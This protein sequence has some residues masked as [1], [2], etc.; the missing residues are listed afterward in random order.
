M[1]ESIQFLKTLEDELAAAGS[2]LALRRRKRSRRLRALAL[3]TVVVAATGF[4]VSQIIG[5]GELVK[6]AAEDPAVT[7]TVTTPAVDSTDSVDSSDSTNS[8]DSPAPVEG[9]PV[10]DR[11]DPAWIPLGPLESRGQTIEVWTGTELIVYGGNTGDE[12]PLLRTG[13][14]Y[15]PVAKSWR[16]IADAPA[17]T[18]SLTGVWTGS[19]LLVSSGTNT[20]FYDPAV[21]SWSQVEAG[22]G[23][24]QIVYL[25]AAYVMNDSG[26]FRFD[27]NQW[28]PLPQP[29]GSIQTKRDQFTSQLLVH[30]DQITV[31]SLTEEYCQGRRLARFD[32][33]SWLELPPVELVSV[34]G[35]FADCSWANQVGVAGGRLIAWE[36]RNF[37]TVALDEQR[38]EWVEIDTIPVSSTEG[39]TGGVTIGN[40]LLVPQSPA[41]VLDGDSLTWHAA[42]LPGPGFD[43]YMVW[44]GDRVLMWGSPCCYGTGGRLTAHDA[45]QWEPT[46]PQEPGSWTV[47]QIRD[48]QAR[49]GATYAIGDEWLFVWGGFPDRSPERPTSSLT[50]NIDTGEASITPFSPPLE[51]RRHAT[52]VWTGTE[53]IVFGGADDEQAYTNGGRISPVE[54]KWSAI[55]KSPFGP[56]TT[57]A[58]AWVADRMFVWMPEPGSPV[59]RRGP[60]Q[61]ASYSP[62]SDTWELLEAPPVSVVG[63]ELVDQGD[64][65]LLVGGPPMRDIGTVAPFPPV[66]IAAY[67]LATGSWDFEREIEEN[68]ESVRTID[69]DGALHIIDDSGF[70]TPLDSERPTIAAPTTGCWYDIATA[71]SSGVTYLKACGGV[72]IYADGRFDPILA[73]GDPASTGNTYGSGFVAVPDGRLVVFGPGRANH[74][75][76]FIG[77]YERK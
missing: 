33:S 29:P 66:Q 12:T 26:I 51:P 75:G 38:G 64:R 77:V 8:T 31:V 55:A 23:S 46:G 10:R 35:G 56:G 76:S 34:A 27:G 28:N 68:G 58:A 57:P 13:A 74:W 20:S 22:I 9:T 53:F 72:Y 62:E 17:G 30:D 71:T 52:T 4:A 1:N 18:G 15:D 50:V 47:K 32:G 67:D 2:Q 54:S 41:S 3:A 6:T 16:S 43:S 59:P 39:G 25:D 5:D 45:W 21:D 49:E 61:F 73:E 37:Q 44:T 69:L 24:G 42:D 11:S 48:F 14:A 36:S 19:Q 70:A 63:A 7:T 60:G 65:I 40:D